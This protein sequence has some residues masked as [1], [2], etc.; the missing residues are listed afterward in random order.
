MGRSKVVTLGRGSWEGPQL[1]LCC[2]LEGLPWGGRPLHHG[3]HH[4]LGL[5]LTQIHTLCCL[6][7][8]H[9]PW[10]QG[11]LPNSFPDRETVVQGGQGF[12]PKSDNSY[13]C[14][15]RDLGLNPATSTNYC[16][17]FFLH[18]LSMLLFDFFN[19]HLNLLREILLL[20]LFYRRRDWDTERGGDLSKVTQLACRGT[21]I[22][23]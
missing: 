8:Q 10:K 20:S 22:L 5:E 9:H 15:W 11:L 23:S 3:Y 13:F 17:M 2:S 21:G 12:H 1:A 14:S 7:A 19:T 18:A 4:L 6:D 16:V